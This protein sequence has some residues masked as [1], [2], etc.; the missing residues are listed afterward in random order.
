MT[1]DQR[2]PFGRGAAAFSLFVGRRKE[3]CVR[4][5]LMFPPLRSE[6]LNRPEKHDQGYE[7]KAPSESGAVLDRAQHL[8]RTACSDQPHQ[9]RSPRL[10]RWRR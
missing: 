9:A 4:L 7:G 10:G 3:E 2:A 6:K 1:D 8:E 5:F